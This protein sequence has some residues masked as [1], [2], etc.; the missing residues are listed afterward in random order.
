[1]VLIEVFG[2]GCVKCRRMNKNVEIVVR[3]LKINADVRKIESLDEMIDRGVMLA[4]A[5]YVD[6]E[7]KVVGHVP[8]V[9]D[10]KQILL[11]EK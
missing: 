11:G 7:P 6:G 5:L 3:E 1:M 9:E 2:T 8:C 10:I 4:P